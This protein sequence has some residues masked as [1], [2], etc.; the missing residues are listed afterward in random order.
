MLVQVKSNSGIIIDSPSCRKRSFIS[1]ASSLAALSPWRHC[2]DVVRR[3]V[4]AGE[5]TMSFM[6]SRKRSLLLLLVIDLHSSTLSTSSRFQLRFPDHPFVCVHPSLGPFV[7]GTRSDAFPCAREGRHPDLLRYEVPDLRD[8][9]V[10]IVCNTA[11][12]HQHK[13]IYLTSRQHNAPNSTSPGRVTKPPLS[14][15]TRYIGSQTCFRYDLTLSFDMWSTR[16]AKV[17]NTAVRGGV[18]L[19]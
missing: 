15:S 12:L 14:S 16:A 2:I 18:H 5:R 9:H 1:C 6:D 3:L 17:W 19:T 11:S 4:F 7:D 10:E 8:K 13:Q